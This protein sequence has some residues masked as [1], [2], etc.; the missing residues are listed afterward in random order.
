MVSNS[1]KRVMPQR[2]R[3]E[4]DKEARRRQLLEGAL[5][6]YRATSYDEVKMADVAE[7][8]RLAKGTVFLYFPT[9]EAL[10]LALLEE[11][12][13]A[14]FPRLEELLARG[15][16]RWTGARVART[17]AE[18]LE[19]EESLT[20]L[21]ARLQTVLEQNVT[22][23]QVRGFKERLLEAVVRAGTLV[24]K[25]LPFLSAG[26]GIHFFLQVHALVVG[27]R[28]MADLAPV[29]REV[30]EAAP[31]LNPLRVD[32]TRELTACLTTLL[33]GLEAR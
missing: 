19:G 20:R 26:E 13:F 9:K 30:H 25:R 24:E 15:E 5:E 2:A 6:L 29:A 23:E 32:F 16:G 31:H 10:F 1:A 22:V 17:V 4:E 28:Q 27:L 18:S 14:W 11:Q 33:R 7:R 8:A 12:L 3:K 21:L